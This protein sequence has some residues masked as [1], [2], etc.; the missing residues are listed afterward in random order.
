MMMF[1]WTVRGGWCGVLK[2]VAVAEWAWS[3]TSIDLSA[4]R[5]L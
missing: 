5:A 1:A 4:G 2:T 3:S